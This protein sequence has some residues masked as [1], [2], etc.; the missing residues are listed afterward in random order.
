MLGDD[1]NYFGQPGTS[2]RYSA[3]FLAQT[4]KRF[5]FYRA[6]TRAITLLTL[7][8]QADERAR[9]Y[10]LKGNI[11]CMKQCMDQYL[12]ILETYVD[13]RDYLVGLSLTID[14]FNDCEELGIVDYCESHHTLAFSWRWIATERWLIE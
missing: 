1:Q 8:R 10:M 14:Y 7:L 9:E 5:E 4:S 12:D 11:A 3:K 13:A 2:S 6:E